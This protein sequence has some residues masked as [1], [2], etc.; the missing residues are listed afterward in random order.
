MDRRTDGLLENKL[1]NCAY[2]DY[3]DYAEFMKIDVAGWICPVCWD[4]FYRAWGG[5]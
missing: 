1:V 5:E 2:C 3:E 4:K